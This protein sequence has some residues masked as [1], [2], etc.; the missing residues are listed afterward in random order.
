MDILVSSKSPDNLRMENKSN[1]YSRYIG[2]ILVC[3]TNDIN[4][5]MI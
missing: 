2:D 4:D 3:N 1:N 5:F